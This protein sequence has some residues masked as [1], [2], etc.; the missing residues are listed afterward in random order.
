[1]NILLINS[2]LNIKILEKHSLCD[3][4][5]RLLNTTECYD[6]NRWHADSK[7]TCKVILWN[8]RQNGWD[9]DGPVMVSILL[10]LFSLS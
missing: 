4:P 6:E 2:C 3:V 9:F 1:M 8:S 5:L 10:K 7:P